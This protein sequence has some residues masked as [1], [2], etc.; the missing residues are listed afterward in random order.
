MAVGYNPSI[1]S[2]G[3]VFFLDPANRRSYSG[4]GLTANGLVG[5]IGGALVNGVGFTSS[6]NGC[7]FFDGSNNYISEPN[8]SIFNFASGFLSISVWVNFSSV[9]GQRSIITNYQSAIGWAVQ[10]YTGVII[11]TSGDYN[12]ITGTKIIQT[13]TWYHIS[14]TGS[15][16]SYKLYINSQS[17]GNIHNGAV[18]FTSAGSLRIGQIANAFYL[19]GNIGQVQIYNRALTQQEILQNFNA[20]RFRYGI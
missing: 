19:N 17:E 8:N 20:T 10:L 12:I 6:N 16:N 13:N 14:I 11:V 18:T 5:G 7:F 15:S 9:S 2:D 1:V 4:S 3:L